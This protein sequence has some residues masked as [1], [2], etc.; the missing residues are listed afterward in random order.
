MREGD[1]GRRGAEEEGRRRGGK[2]T[3]GEEDSWGERRLGIRGRGEEGGLVARRE[4]GPRIESGRR[5]ERT[6]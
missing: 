1:E 6:G 3:E 4:E 5:R 2:W